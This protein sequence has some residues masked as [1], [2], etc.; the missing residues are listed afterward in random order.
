MM[1]P[2]SASFCVKQPA[3]ENICVATVE[4]ATVISDAETDRAFI[5]LIL[6]NIEDH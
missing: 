3:P 6:A 5:S 4:I 1:N 2:P